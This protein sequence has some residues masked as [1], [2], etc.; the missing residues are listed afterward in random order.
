MTPVIF[1]FCLPQ[2]TNLVIF[3][4]QKGAAGRRKGHHGANLHFPAAYNQ[5]E[6]EPGK[7]NRLHP[8]MSSL[9]LLTVPPASSLLHGRNIFWWFYSEGGVEK[10]KL[11][12][13]FYNQIRINLNS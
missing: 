13:W 6:F 11:V 7:G 9:D 4:V 8:V 5:A 2:Q 10:G 3:L 1:I 12:S